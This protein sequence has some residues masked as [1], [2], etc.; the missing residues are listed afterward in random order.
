MTRCLDGLTEEEKLQLPTTMGQLLESIAVREDICP[1]CLK[2]MTTHAMLVN[3]GLS[4]AAAHMEV[5][6][7]GSPA[8]R[9]DAIRRI[10]KVCD[11][12]C[13]VLQ[14]YDAPVERVN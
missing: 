8:L 2:Y 10:Q 14:S 7:V 9:Q 6:D 12:I 4:T 11:D 1:Q 3:Y 5:V 13:S